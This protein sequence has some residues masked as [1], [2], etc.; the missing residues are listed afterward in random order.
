M[1]VEFRHVPMGVNQ[2]LV[3]HRAR[4]RGRHGRSRALSKHLRATFAEWADP[5]P[6]IL[7]ATPPDRLLRNDLYDRATARRWARG[8]WFW[9]ATPPIPMRPHLGQGGCRAIEDAA[10]LARLL[11]S[12]SDPATA[13][14][15]FEIPPPR[16]RALV[17]ESRTVGAVLNVRPAVLAA[18]LTRAT[19]VITE[20]VN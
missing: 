17:R 19:A 9:W 2:T 5:V 16:V 7:A 14:A 8:P 13:F 1:G 3:R 10:V 12:A 11:G 18:G 20:A 6:A 15:R 4:R